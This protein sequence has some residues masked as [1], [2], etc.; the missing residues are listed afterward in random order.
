MA[1]PSEC[2]WEFQQVEREYISG[3][4][5]RVARAQHRGKTG[6]LFLTPAFFAR[7]LEMPMVAHRFKGSFAVDLLFQSPQ[8]LFDGLAFLQF[9][10]GQNTFTSSP[11]T[12]GFVRSKATGAP[13]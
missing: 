10:L 12:F 7:F 2:R 13:L 9:N 1:R 8:G 6:G 4:Q 11:E 3:S 5:I